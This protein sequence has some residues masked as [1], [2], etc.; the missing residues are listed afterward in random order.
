MELND[1]YNDKEYER[2]GRRLDGEDVELTAEQQ[3][4]ADD[5]IA[6]QAALAGRLDAPAPPHALRHARR[7]MAGELARPRHNNLMRLGTY[8]AAAAAVAAVVVVAVMV[9]PDPKLTSNGGPAIAIQTVLYESADELADQLDQIE[10]AMV[11]GDELGFSIDELERDLD[12]FWS[13]D[14]PEAMPE[15]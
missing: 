3:A 5:I 12:D 13:F 7:R 10:A 14:D 1:I 15:S 11:G 9:Q 6:A 4:V 2:I 8:A